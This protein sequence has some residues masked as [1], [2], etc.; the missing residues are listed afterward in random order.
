MNASIG[1]LKYSWGQR[2]YGK[3]HASRDNKKVEMN[4]EKETLDTQ[5]SEHTY[6]R[7]S[8]KT[9]YIPQAKEEVE[10]LQKW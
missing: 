6:S 10:V 3:P 5:A 4:L 7:V 1:V 9:L 2:S 8:R